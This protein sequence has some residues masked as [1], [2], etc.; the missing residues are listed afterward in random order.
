MDKFRLVAAW[1]K[2]AAEIKECDK[3]EHQKVD[4]KATITTTTDNDNGND[5]DYIKNIDD[6]NTDEDEAKADKTETDDFLLIGSWFDDQLNTDSATTT[7]T[8]GFMTESATTTTNA[9][10]NAIADTDVTDVTAAMAGTT[11]TT[12]TGELQCDGDVS[13][14]A[15][16]ALDTTFELEQTDGVDYGVR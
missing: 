7:A 11:T 9:N 8:N 16:Q 4:W 1:K 13:S 10:T 14:N 6:P 5:N 15:T 2:E 12:A 3:S